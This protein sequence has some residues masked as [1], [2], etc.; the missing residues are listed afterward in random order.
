LRPQSLKDS[1]CG[2]RNRGRVRRHSEASG[3]ESDLGRLLSYRSLVS[4]R[5]RASCRAVTCTVTM[6]RLISTRTA[7]GVVR[8]SL[9]RW[10]TPDVDK[11]ANLLASKP[12]P[13][14]GIG[15][16]RQRDLSHV[17]IRRACGSW[18]TPATP[19]RPPAAA[20]TRSAIRTALRAGQD[21]IPIAC[22]RAGSAS[23]ARSAGYV[24]SPE[25]PSTLT[26]TRRPPRLRHTGSPPRGS[27]GRRPP[28]RPLARTTDSKQQKQ[29]GSP[30]E[31]A[32]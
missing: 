26:T 11:A 1:S 21:G 8:L 15:A 29:E 13:P 2:Q 12:R 20:T 18:A 25:L 9:G 5:H 23:C 10:T 27:A 4:C 32:V 16:D 6:K 17:R 14:Q 22:I 31:P 7:P 28:V 30:A 3:G 24:A 19:S